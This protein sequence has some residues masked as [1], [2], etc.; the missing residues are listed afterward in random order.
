[1]YRPSIQM[2]RKKRVEETN[3]VLDLK[4]FNKILELTIELEDLKRKYAEKIKNLNFLFEETRNS[5]KN[6]IQSEIKKIDSD[7]VRIALQKIEISSSA[8]LDDFRVELTSAIRGLKNK[9]EE[10]ETVFLHIKNIQKGD[11]GMNGTNGMNGE[12]GKDAVVN[13]EKIINEIVK[14]LLDKKLK[15]ENIYGLTETIR[16]LSSKTMLGG[17][18]GGGQGSWKQKTL[19]GTINGSNTVFTFTGDP[20]AEF[21]ETVYLNY[22]A[23][24]PFTDYTI[25]GNTV[26]YTTAPDASLSG[27][28]HIIRGM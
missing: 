17:K 19:S 13:E 23:Q 1:M 14:L 5:V 12:K 18:V 10:A 3:S 26:T 27:L 24:N 21:S 28:P 9:T 2:P 20:L 22:L 6:S 8:M 7:F 15:M 25:S 4:E 16:H 11:K